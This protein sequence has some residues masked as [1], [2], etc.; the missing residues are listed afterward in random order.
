MRNIRLFTEKPPLLQ[1]DVLEIGPGN[2]ELILSLA[3]T[4]P[5]TTF[6]AIE[7]RRSRFHRLA[8]KIEKLNLKNIFIVHGNARTVVPNF[9]PKSLEKIYILFPDPWPKRRHAFRRLLNPEFLFICTR[10]LSEGGE[11]FLATDVETYGQQARQI[12]AQIRELKEMSPPSGFFLPGDQRQTGFEQKWTRQGK[13]IT[14]LL[15][16]RA[17]A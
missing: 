6:A 16:Q 14:K 1:A 9:K 15:F 2:G 4:F 13:S 10:C 17:I 12:L 5:D 8:L 11:L 3:Q 7:V